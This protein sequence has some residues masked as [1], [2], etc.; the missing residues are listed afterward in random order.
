M[1][2]AASVAPAS[3]RESTPVA[4]AAEYCGY[5]NGSVP[6]RIGDTGDRVKEVQCLIN[7]WSGFEQLAVDGRFGLKV[8]S[9]VVHVQEVNGLRV[10]GVV[11]PETWRVLRAERL[12]LRDR[13]SATPQPPPA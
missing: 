8:R 12:S 5:Y 4:G 1:A 7:R 2:L 10:D 6:T 3:A 9:W 11:G 13:A